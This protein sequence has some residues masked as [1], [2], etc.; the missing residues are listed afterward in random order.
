MRPEFKMGFEKTAVLGFGMSK[1]LISNLGGRTG[2]KLLNYAKGLGTKAIDNPGKAL[3]IGATAYF[4]GDEALNVLG[5]TRSRMD[6]ATQ[7]GT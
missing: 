6:N 2:T 3:G 4:A 1:S 7:M 5:K